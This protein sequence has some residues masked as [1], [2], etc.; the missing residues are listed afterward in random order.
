MQQRT[1]RVGHLVLFSSGYEWVSI[2][3]TTNVCM[4]ISYA[5]KIPRIECL[6]KPSTS[7]RKDMLRIKEF[8][9]K[10]WEQRC[11]YRSGAFNSQ[12]KNINSGAW[13]T[14]NLNYMPIILK[15]PTL[16]G[17]VAQWGKAAD[18]K[19]NYLSLVLELHVVEKRN[20][21]NF[22]KLFFDLHTHTMCTHKSPQNNK[23]KTWWSTSNSCGPHGSI[24]KFS[25][26]GSEQN[27]FYDKFDFFKKKSFNN[28]FYSKP[29]SI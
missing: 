6:H 12:K 5:P 16:A 18:A 23:C 8:Y 13:K 29:T 22:Q 17:K 14:K 21:N 3:N 15:S 24:F 19:P 9:R 2:P 4:R 25:W 10:W 11:L 1:S 26:A 27:I 20:Q 28:S 7:G